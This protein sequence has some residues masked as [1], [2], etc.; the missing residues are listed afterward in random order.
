MHIDLD[1]DPKH[2]LRVVQPPLS[3]HNEETE[4]TKM[5]TKRIP[6]VQSTSYT[7]YIKLRHLFQVDGLKRLMTETLGRAEGSASEWTVEDTIGML[8]LSRP[9]IN[10]QKFKEVFTV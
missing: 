3:S 9:S 5:E 10:M 8:Q 1:P 7:N 6:E 4:L 2:W